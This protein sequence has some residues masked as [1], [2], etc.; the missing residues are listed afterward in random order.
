MVFSLEEKNRRNGIWF[1]MDSP[2]RICKPAWQRLIIMLCGVTVNFILALVLFAMILFVWGEERL[3][4]KNMAYGL[5]VDSL[6]Q[7]A[8]LKDGDKVTAVNNKPVT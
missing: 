4:V 5:S 6:A 3:P 8:G 7:S 2:G 1:G